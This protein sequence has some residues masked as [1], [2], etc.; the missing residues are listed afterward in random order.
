[1]AKCNKVNQYLNNVL[2]NSK[3]GYAFQ[4]VSKVI[5]FGLYSWFKQSLIYFTFFF[6]QSLMV[7][8]VLTI[9]LSFC[10]GL[11]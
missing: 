9:H 11:S 5:K 1:M 10:I 8:K 3:I 4:Y 6:S 2:M 7:S